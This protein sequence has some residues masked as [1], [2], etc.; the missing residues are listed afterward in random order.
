MVLLY[1]ILQPNKKRNGSILKNLNGVIPFKLAPTKGALSS[2]RTSSR[3]RATPRRDLYSRARRTGPAGFATRHA[4]A[5]SAEHQSPA[6]ADQ[7][8]RLITQG[9]AVQQAAAIVVWSSV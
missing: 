5:G 3:A 1:R 7:P 8:A 4:A 9:A 2:R 6:P